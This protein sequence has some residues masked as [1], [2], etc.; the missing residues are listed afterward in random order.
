MVKGVSGRQ[1]R[2]SKQGSMM[3]F[4]HEILS[5]SQKAVRLIYKGL[6]PRNSGLQD[7]EYAQLLAHWDADPAFRDEVTRHASVM[8]LSVIHVDNRKIFLRPSHEDSIFAPRLSDIRANASDLDRGA[9]ALIFIAVGAA[10]FRTGG[11][12]VGRG[13]QDPELTAE[14]IESILD[15]LCTKLAERNPEDPA[16]RDQVLHE[17][18]RIL[19]SKPRRTETEQRASMATRLGMVKIVIS[20]LIDYDMLIENRAGEV[21]SYV[22]T[23]RFRLQLAEVLTNEIY[24]RCIRELDIEPTIVS[25][26]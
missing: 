20:R 4:G 1:H 26:E 8:E 16:R 2:F 14:Q 17:G 13:D 7:A 5:E 25:P 24:D 15:E 21:D 6:R 10:F 23:E 19:L 22:P 11:D 12:L 3:P 9:L 18:W